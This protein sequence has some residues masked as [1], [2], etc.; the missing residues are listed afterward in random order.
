MRVYVSHMISFHQNH[1]R[2]WA[3]NT[4]IGL[5]VSSEL[6]LLTS[7]SHSPDVITEMKSQVRKAVRDGL[8]SVPCRLTSVI[9]N[10]FRL[11]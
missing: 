5:P 7:E 11:S 8:C 10:Q 1:F 9:P 4:R 2:A 3:R 6:C